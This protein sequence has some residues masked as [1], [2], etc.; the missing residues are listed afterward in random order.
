M[1]WRAKFKNPI[2]KKAIF[3]R[4][5]KLRKASGGVFIDKEKFL[6]KL[7]KGK[8]V[9]DWGIVSDRCGEG[10]EKRPRWLHGHIS[11][12][13][14]YC[15]GV[16]IKKKE[17]AELKNA[18]Y[19]VRVADITKPGLDFGDHN[20]DIIIASEIIEHLSRLEN[21]FKT[22]RKSLSKRGRLVITT[23]N[24][25]WIVHAVTLF[26]T[27]FVSPNV[28]HTVWFCPSTITETVER[29]GFHLYQ[30]Y[31]I[32]KN[33]QPYG[34]I[35]KL[36]MGINNLLGRILGSYSFAPNYLYIL[37]KTA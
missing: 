7:V 13:A 10:Y 17:L 4:M 14:R 32:L 25:H 8:K 36:A 11:R 3:W 21:F 9:M 23:P 12:N 15:L 26:L 27:N 16:D 2:S 24:P 33:K 6:G 20:Y 28:D 19:N 1:K 35:K 22:A 29:N 34:G 31:G 5:D 37:K 18:G 30:Y